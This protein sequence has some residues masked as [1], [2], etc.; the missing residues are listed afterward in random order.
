MKD[1]TPI[2]PPVL[3]SRNYPPVNKY[4]KLLDRQ[5]SVEGSTASLIS[6]AIGDSKKLTDTENSYTPI[7]NGSSTI[8]SHSSSPFQKVRHTLFISLIRRSF[9][10]I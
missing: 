8:E 7:T 9:L 6:E 2:E 3:A 10:I 1:I 5:D 4:S